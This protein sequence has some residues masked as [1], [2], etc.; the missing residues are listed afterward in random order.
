MLQSL[1]QSSNIGGWFQWTI[2]IMNIAFSLTHLPIIFMNE[3]KLFE[4]ESACA[5]RG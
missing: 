4:V 2:G 3:W 5:D 1:N